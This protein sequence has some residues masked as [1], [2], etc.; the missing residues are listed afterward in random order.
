MIALK[1]ILVP[2][3]FERT[4]EHALNYG[5]ELAR[6][7]NA[8]LHVLHVVDDVFA[9]SAGTEGTLTAFPR[10][11]RDMEDSAH[12]QIE[13]LVTDEDRKAGIH[14]AVVTSSSPAQA[15]IERA[16]DAEADLIV[17]GTH[18]RGG[19]PSALIGSVAER[20]VRTASCP[21]LS[22]RHPRDEFVVPGGPAA[23]AGG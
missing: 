12:S 1:K 2:V 20:V 23:R 17:M 11:K 3:D 8:T 5:R 13:T 6:R 10:L 9:L 15:I 16:R 18:G 14:V 7:F 22:I 4:S 19:A 21:V